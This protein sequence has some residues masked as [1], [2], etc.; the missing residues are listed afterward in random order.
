M[1]TTKV[2]K[3]TI[4][5]I[6][7]AINKTWVLELS[8]LMK[9]TLEPFI[10]I[11]YDQEPVKQFVWDHIVLVSDAAHPIPPMDSEAQTCQSLI[12]QGFI[13]SNLLEH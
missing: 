10:N 8:A 11:L 12:K 3:C 6:H 7:E 9:V 2:V 1:L 5:K 13:I 4:E